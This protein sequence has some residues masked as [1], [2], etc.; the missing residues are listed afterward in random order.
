MVYVHKGVGRGTP[1]E[2]VGQT[3]RKAKEWYN[4]VIDR[5]IDELGDIVAEELGAA[6]VNNL[7][8]K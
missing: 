4:P 1:I 8:I 6:I 7:F 3:K 2:K 5:R